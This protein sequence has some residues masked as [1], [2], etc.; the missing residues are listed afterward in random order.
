[1][2]LER[3]AIKGRKSLLCSKQPANVTQP[4]VPSATEFSRELFGHSQKLKT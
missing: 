3:L 4:I 1:M 2:C